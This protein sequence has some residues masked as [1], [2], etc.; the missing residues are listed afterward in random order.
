[1]QTSRSKN[2]SRGSSSTRTRSPPGTTRR[3]DRQRSESEDSDGGSERS[4]FFG[5]V[6]ALPAQTISSASASA[7]DHRLMGGSGGR[8]DGQNGKRSHSR[9]RSNSPRTPALSAQ[10][11]SG[12]MSAGGGGLQP[13]HAHRRR[14]GTGKTLNLKYAM[15]AIVWFHRCSHCY[16]S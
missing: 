12:S 7:R 4:P 11:N 9:D 16:L 6:G 5:T 10:S 15:H 8:L 1:M 2:Q 3:R 13:L 14:Q